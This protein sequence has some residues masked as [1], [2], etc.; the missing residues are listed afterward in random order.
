M[1]ETVESGLSAR[2]AEAGFGHAG[3]VSRLANI[4]P[5]IQGSR[6]GS[7][8]RIVQNLLRFKN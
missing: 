1:D 5:K 3:K 4:G 8:P 2:Y 6:S 7:L